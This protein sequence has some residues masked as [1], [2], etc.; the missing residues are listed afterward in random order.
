MASN[1]L[2]PIPN[3]S[4]R[5]S[6]ETKIV[7]PAATIPPPTPS[8]PITARRISVSAAIKP[9]ISKSS[10]EK[11]AEAAELTGKRIVGWGITQEADS[12]APVLV[13]LVKGENDQTLARYELHVAARGVTRSPAQRT[14]LRPDPGFLSP[15]LLGPYKRDSL[16]ES[17]AVE[18]TDDLQS[19]V[20]IISA[21]LVPRPGRAWENNGAVRLVDNQVLRLM[22]ES[23]PEPSEESRSEPGHAR[24]GSIGPK[25]VF[26]RARTTERDRARN[27][28]LGSHVP[29]D[30]SDEEADHVGD[31]TS[32]GEDVI[33]VRV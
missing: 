2:T 20:R 26:V 11:P 9:T 17:S 1:A 25:T 12:P 27:S 31:R 15:N 16:D 10:V 18:A 5:Q 28:N 24:S 8:N 3:L 19:G 22:L 13:L 23:P 32:I 14:H 6:G 29:N 30:G 4:D 7:I 21:A 33:L